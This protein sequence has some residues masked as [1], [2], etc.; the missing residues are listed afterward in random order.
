MSTLNTTVTCVLSSVSY[1]NL[2]MSFKYLLIHKGTVNHNHAL[3]PGDSPEDTFS[4]A[5]HTAHSAVHGGL[6]LADKGVLLRI[7]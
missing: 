1:L 4:G 6:A 3:G 5:S 2:D 7:Q